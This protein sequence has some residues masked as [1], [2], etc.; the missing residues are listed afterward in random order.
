MSTHAAIHGTCLCGALRYEVA[1]PLSMM[2]NCHCSMCRKHHGSA[3]ATFVAAPLMTF[4]WHQGESNVLHF[5]SSEHGVRSSC[6]TCGSVAPT[7]VKQMDL[8]FVP[9]GNLLGDL[10]LRPQGHVFVGSKAPWYEITDDLPQ[11]A[12]YPPQF[13]MG[14]V[15]Q[16]AR[17]TRA[18][19]I[20]GGCLCGDVA[21]ELAGLPEIVQNCHCSRCRRARSAAH[22]TNAFFRREQLTWIRGED[23][24][25]NFPLPGAKRFGQ[26]FCRRC[27]GAVPRAVASTGYAVVPCGCLDDPPGRFPRGHIFMGSK[28]PWYEVTDTLPRWDELPA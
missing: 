15:A 25:E 11:H 13:G 26:A 6:R 2:I 4:R 19:V 28:A 1:G 24:V 20:S 9:A 17:P 23:G 27:G 14:G 10:P 7:P 22:A 16:P 3:Y 5:R 12:E 8:V 18:G 21:F